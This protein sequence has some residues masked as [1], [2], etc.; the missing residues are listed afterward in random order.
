MMDGNGTEQTFWV[1]PAL[2]RATR[3][4]NIAIYCVRD[5]TPVEDRTLQPRQ[6]NV[7][8]EQTLCPK[9]SLEYADPSII[10]LKAQRNICIGKESYADYGE[11]YSFPA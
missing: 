11:S 1:V 7:A 9:S 4:V 8:F 2:F 6:N 10:H 3:Y 5:R